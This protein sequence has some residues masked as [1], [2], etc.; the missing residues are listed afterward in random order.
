M[1]VP[2]SWSKG[3]SI[4]MLPPK[5]TD[6]TDRSLFKRSR[7]RGFDPLGYVNNEG[8]RRSIFYKSGYL[9]CMKCN[10]IT[11][12]DGTALRTALQLKGVLSADL[13]PEESLPPCALCGETRGLRVGAQ[14]FTHLIQ[15][16]KEELIRRRRLERKSAKDLQRVYRRYLGIKWGKAEKARQRTLLLLGFRSAQVI[17][18]IVRGRLGRRVYETEKWLAVIK[19]AHR[20]LI[21]HALKGY[22]NRKKVYWYKSEAEEEQL[23]RDYRELVKRTGFRPP[24]LVVE[25][26]IR[27]IG[28]SDPRAGARGPAGAEDPSQVERAQRAEVHARLS[29]GAE[30]ATG[31]EGGHGISFAAHRAREGTAA[32]T[33]RGMKRLREA[34]IAER[35]QEFTARLM[36]Y[37]EPK[38]YGG[39]KMTAFHESPYGD[40]S[41]TTLM[42]EQQV[43]ALYRKQV[44]E[45]REEAR[46]KERGEWVRLRQ[47]EDPQL[48]RYFHEEVTA[49][50]QHVISKLGADRQPFK[51]VGAAL[52]KQNKARRK[53]A[54]PEK[55]RTLHIPVSFVHNLTDPQRCS[56]VTS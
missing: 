34:Y 37:T 50:N 41:V 23:Y 33:A 6:T 15:G 9:S 3:S 40:D 53:Y 36:G 21:D 27:E 38:L 1:C 11:F 10:G 5:L 35:Q 20:L 7:F 48:A 2:A 25:E 8:L 47:L 44:T 24:R 42:N 55:V 29:K 26:N 12:V 16:G 31:G 52:R 13:I 51:S 32:A 30:E 49:R 18:A 46:R 4:H 56:T 54:F 14:D 22:P 17:Q 45:R 19:K 43:Q 39:K 28:S